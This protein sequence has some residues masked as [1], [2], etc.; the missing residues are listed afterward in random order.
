MEKCENLITSNK[1]HR[2]TETRPLNSVDS[3]FL[4]LPL[5][6]LDGVHIWF[7]FQP[8][9][10]VWSKLKQINIL[11]NRE[12][13]PW[14]YINLAKYLH[15]PY[16]YI[17]VPYIYIYYIYI[18]YTY[19]SACRIHTCKA[20]QTSATSHWLFPPNAPNCWWLC[21]KEHLLASPQPRWRHP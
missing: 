18:C 14:W 7:M 1:I 3:I 9:C 2:L 16:I 11:A 13:L 4:R 5:L 20:T 12:Q 17:Y 8:L 19:M 21:Q 15:V 6:P 10:K